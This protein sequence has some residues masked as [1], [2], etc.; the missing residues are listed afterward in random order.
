MVKKPSILLPPQF[1]Q[2]SLSLFLAQ[3]LQKVNSNVQINTS[4]DSGGKSLLQHSQFGLNSSKG[5]NSFF[6]MNSLE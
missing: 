1:G 4:F 3:S 2:I 5:L 6:W